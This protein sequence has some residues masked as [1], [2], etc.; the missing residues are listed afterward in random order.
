MSSVSVR[1]KG[2]FSINSGGGGSVFRGFGWSGA[3]STE[4]SG[5]CL[6][7]GDGCIFEDLVC[8]NRIDGF[9]G[10]IFFTIGSPRFTSNVIFRRIRF[11][12]IGDPS[13]NNHDHPLYIKNC[14]FTRVEDCLFY[15]ITDGWCF[16][17]YNNG[18]DTTVQ[19]ITAANVNAGIT[20]SGAN[21]SSTGLTGCYSSDRNIVEKSILM[22]CT[23]SGRY[24]VESYWGCSPAGVGN[25]VRDSNVYQGSG[26][27]GRINSSSGGFTTSNLQ[28]T[29]PLFVNPSV[30]D[31][32]LSSNSPSIGYGPQQ[33]QPGGSTPSPPSPVTNLA[34]TPGDTQVALSWTNPG[35]TWDSIVIVRKTGSYSTSPADGT[36]IYDSTGT[37]HTD[38]GLTNGTTYYYSVY[39]RAGGTY[40]SPAQISAQ[41][42]AASPPPP[43]PGDD[44]APGT[45]KV[46][47]FPAGTT[48]F[49]GMS[50]DA[51]RAFRF[52]MPAGK[53]FTTFWARMRGSGT[54][55]STQPIKVVVYNANTA[56]RLGVSNERVLAENMAEQWVEFTVASPIKGPPSGGDILLGFHSGLRSGTPTGEVQYSFDSVAGGLL[57]N[58]DVYS[59]GPSDPFG[60]GTTD[61]FVGSVFGVVQNVPS[62]PGGTELDVSFSGRGDWQ[63]DAELGGTVPPALR[64]AYF[65]E[66]EGCTCCDGLG[67]RDVSRPYLIVDGQKEGR[68]RWVVGTGW[69]SGP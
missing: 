64:V 10:R 47:K 63:V 28:N 58:S 12:L 36:T 22:N 67:V 40:S 14:Q 65:P 53:Q 21:D 52:T 3:V 45:E 23:R 38:T 60:S 44:P 13:R 37:S 35:G 54:G 31:Y 69:V 50:P 46:G 18:D 29:D 66:V 55:S 39:T 24:L 17:F 9:P 5:T 43:Q 1:L 48:G 41:P 42:Q 19:R 20:F 30:G 33:L 7:N 59:D 2:R 51:K 26:S 27:G 68:V 15:E 49:K 25:V 62:Q 4:A 57:V 61:N 11:R 56:A 34:A 8:M 16:H 6:V 32:R